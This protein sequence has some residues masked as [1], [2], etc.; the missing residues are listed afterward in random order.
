MPAGKYHSAIVKTGDVCL[1]ELRVK[2]NE[3]EAFA[4]QRHS[5]NF[6]EQ[7]VIENIRALLKAKAK[8]KGLKHARKRS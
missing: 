1:E 2:A 5:T 3:L 6:K 8:A 4:D 7:A